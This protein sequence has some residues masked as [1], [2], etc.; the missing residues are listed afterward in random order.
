VQYR[1]LTGGIV[2][3]HRAVKPAPDAPA[4]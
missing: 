3:V 4:R 1:N 2:A